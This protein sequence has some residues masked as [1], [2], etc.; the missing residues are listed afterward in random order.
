MGIKDWF[1][2]DKKKEALREKV[3]EA[4]S[5]GRLSSQDIKEIEEH[6]Q[7]LGAEDIR[8]DRTIIRRGIYNEAVAAVKKDG[9][10]TATDAHELAKIQKFL[11]LRDDQIEKTR[12]DLARLRRLTEIRGG[13]LPTVTPGNA[14]LRGIQFEEGEIAHYSLQVDM[15]DQGSTRGAD[16]VQAEWGKPYESGAAR[17]HVLPEAGA[18]PIGEGALVFTNRR[19][20]V[21]TGSRVAAIKYAPDAQIYLYSDGL[22]LQ[23]T[24]GNTLLKYRSGSEETGEI[25]AE[26][27][28]ALMR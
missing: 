16:G 8:G 9:E 25:V 27:L 13:N 28:A 19:L 11:A 5:D 23:R 14:A 15:F 21:K 10:V 12:W 17:V 2:G 6:R 20:I 22:R 18:K 7:E 1:G 26:L 3:K 4:V 24:I